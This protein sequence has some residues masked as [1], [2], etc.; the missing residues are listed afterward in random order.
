M[1]LKF[2][3][4]SADF[5]GCVLQDGF[6]FTSIDQPS[7]VLDAIVIRNPEKAFSFTP[8]KTTST[9]TLTET[10]QYIAE[11]KIEKACIIAED[12]SF[13]KDCPSLRKVELILATTAPENFDFSPLYA[14]PNLSSFACVTEFGMPPKPKTISL[15]YTNFPPLEE[16]RASGSG[17]QDIGALQSLRKLNLSEHALGKDL[18]SICTGEKLEQLSLTQCKVQSLQGI[19]KETNLK[20]VSL[21]YLRNLKDISALQSTAKTLSELTI[22]NCPKI[23][24]FSVLN[25]LS[26]LEHLALD[27]K[28]TLPSLS[29]L[30]SMPKLQTFTFSMTVADKDI[31]PCLAIPYVYM[32]KDKAGY[33]LKNKDL[34]KN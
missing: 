33:N 29:F 24:D 27:G 4:A 31:K 7:N 1:N 32:A 5:L 16:L 23:I 10:I 19:E 2:D 17:H 18:S 25:S 12:I 28:N 6:V 30:K 20:R 8:Q 14:M 9:R 3:V 22:E 11:N 34:P 15:S 26:N 21:S 13:L